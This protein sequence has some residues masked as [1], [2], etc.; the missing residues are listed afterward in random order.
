VTS[1][2]I[3]HL[4]EVWNLGNIHKIDHSK[5]L[6]FLSDTPEC[7][8]HHHAL[9]VT[10]GTEPNDNDTIILRKYGLIDVP[11]RRKMRKEVT[12][13]MR[14]RYRNEDLNNAIKSG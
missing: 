3:T 4:V 12:H 2:R 11:P 8:V 10:V 5:V 9:R 6:H 14:T 7:F 13:L 1:K